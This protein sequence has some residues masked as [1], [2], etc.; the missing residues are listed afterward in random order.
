MPP[1]FWNLA[2]SRSV[3]KY[4]LSTKKTSTPRKPPGI[5]DIPSWNASTASTASARTPSRPGARQPA[6]A[7]DSASMTVL[8]VAV[9]LAVAE[10]SAV[11]VNPAADSPFPAEVGCTA[12][13]CPP[14]DWH[15]YQRSAM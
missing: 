2:T 12:T 13:E 8:D 3:I 11:M 5:H 15:E 6:L 7:G 4:P 10:D 1:F 14:W 9:G